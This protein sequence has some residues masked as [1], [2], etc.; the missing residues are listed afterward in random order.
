MLLERVTDK[1]YKAR[2]ERV[3]VF[4]LEAWDR[5]CPQHIRPRLTEEELAPSIAALQERIADLQAQLEEK[6]ST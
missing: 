3:F 6:R 1:G 2:L 5:N 4:D